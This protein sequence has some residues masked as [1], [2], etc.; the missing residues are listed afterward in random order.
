MIGK[1]VIQIGVSQSKKKIGFYFLH[2]N[3]CVQ[4][5]DS[6][7][8]SLDEVQDFAGHLS[9]SLTVTVQSFSI[10]PLQLPQ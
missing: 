8:L 6:L 9:D 2:P 3:T 7:T 10:K 1:L 5:V 4:D